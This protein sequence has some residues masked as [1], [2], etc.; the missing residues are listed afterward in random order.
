MK[1]NNPRG[2]KKVTGNILNMKARGCRPQLEKELRPKGVMT[3]NVLILFFTIHTVNSFLPNLAQDLKNKQQRRSSEI[4]GI[5]NQGASGW[6]PFRKN[7][8]KFADDRGQ[9]ASPVMGAQQ[10]NVAGDKRPHDQ[11]SLGFSM[12]S[13]VSRLWG[14][15]GTILLQMPYLPQSPRK[16]KL[17]LRGRFQLKFKPVDGK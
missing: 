9:G 4:V 8:V 13:H 15:E 17:R 12:T 6:T 14:C 2:N 5:F 16:F 1:P 10:L 7:C 3:I 11:L